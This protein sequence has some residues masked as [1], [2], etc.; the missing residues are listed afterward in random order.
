M[1]APIANSTTIQ[2]QSEISDSASGV[3]SAIPDVNDVFSNVHFFGRD[4]FF[5]SSVPWLPRP[6]GKG[7]GPGFIRIPVETAFESD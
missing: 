2:I 6:P 3:N 5:S 7:I 4:S 1:L